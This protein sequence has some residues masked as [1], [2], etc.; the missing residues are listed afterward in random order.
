MKRDLFVVVADLDAENAIK[1]L[2]LSRQEALRIQLDFDPGIDLMRWSGRDPGCCK[3]AVDLLRTP[4]NGYKHAILLF[5]KHGCGEDQKPRESLE[6]EIEEQLYRNGWSVDSVAVIIFD[7]ELEAWVWSNSPQVS[8]IM[9]WGSNLDKL[10]AFIREKDL[11]SPDGTKP[12]D[13]KAAMRTAMRSAG[14]PCT[15]T[16]FAELAEKVSTKGCTDPSFNKFVGTLQKWFPCGR[17]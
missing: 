14:R 16:V 11:L 1:T 13:P 17:S 8:K 6:R 9:G 7:P 3:N 2:L 12:S 10:Q 4:Q 15:A 5:D